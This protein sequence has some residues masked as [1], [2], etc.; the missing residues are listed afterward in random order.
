MAL[1]EPVFTPFAHDAGRLWIEKISVM[2]FRVHNNVLEVIS[3]KFISHL[4][5]P[6]ENM[7]L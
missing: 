7:N 4:N 1:F 5:Q 6:Y 3:Q 2:N